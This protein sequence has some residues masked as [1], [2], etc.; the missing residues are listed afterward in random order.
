MDRRTN[1]QMDRPTSRVARTH[2]KDRIAGKM[3]KSSALKVKYAY[4]NLTP[5]ILF[6]YCSNGL[7]DVLNASI[8]NKDS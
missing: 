2:L 3:N 6:A 7:I 8:V 1:R 5:K 4:F